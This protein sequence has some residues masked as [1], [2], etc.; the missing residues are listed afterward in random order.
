MQDIM[1]HIFFSPLS[2]T[3]KSLKDIFLKNFHSHIT[4]AKD[5]HVGKVSSKNRETTKMKNKLSDR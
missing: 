5:F 3:D 4:F 2:K 1:Y